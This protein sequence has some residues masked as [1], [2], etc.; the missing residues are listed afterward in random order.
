MY[1]TTGV[2]NDAP[3]FRATWFPPKDGREPRMHLSFGV[4]LAV[5]VTLDELR[6]LA[7]VIEDAFQLAI[8]GG[9]DAEA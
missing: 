4:D 1:I 2:V 7:Q 5:I 3:E 8:Q 6:Q 9:R